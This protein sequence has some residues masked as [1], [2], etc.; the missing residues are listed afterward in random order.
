MKLSK[1]QLELKKAQDRAKKLQQQVEREAR[2]TFTALPSKV[3][4]KTVDELITAL[5]P[6]ASSATR[7][8]LAK[9]T[10]SPASTSSTS[11]AQTSVTSAR[12]PHSRHTSAQKAMIKQAM[13]RGA[14]LSELATKHGIPYGTLK[15]WKIRWG[16]TKKRAVAKAK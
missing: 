6:Y 12:R 11:A 15:K 16:L 3:G 9:G 14:P 10:S 8:K 1:L 13:Q 5:L 2:A 7:A 4:L